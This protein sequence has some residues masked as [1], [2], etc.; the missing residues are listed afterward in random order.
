MCDGH[1]INGHHASDHV[2]KFLPSNI[3]FIDYMAIKNKGEVSK[4]GASPHNRENK[5]RRAVSKSRGNSPMTSSNNLEDIAN[6]STESQ[7]N[8]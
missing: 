2:K 8:D 6:Q 4:G 7:N 1:G 3:E 5:K